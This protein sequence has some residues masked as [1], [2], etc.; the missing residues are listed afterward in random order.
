MEKWL[1]KL[2]QMVYR[3]FCSEAEKSPGS[4]SMICQGELAPIHFEL[5]AR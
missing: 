3:L 5:L 1:R 4:C 2:T